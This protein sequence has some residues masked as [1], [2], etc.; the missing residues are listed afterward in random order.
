MWIE[1]LEE[2]PVL[3]EAALLLKKQALGV[4]G[5]SRSIIVI[6]RSDHLWSG[7]LTFKVG[8]S[9]FLWIWLVWPFLHW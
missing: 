6:E 1:E 7:A 2:L 9:A 3:N 5:A 4:G 8:C